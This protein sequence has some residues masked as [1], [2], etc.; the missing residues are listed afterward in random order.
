[1]RIYIIGFMGSGKTIFG[2]RLAAYSNFDFLDLDAY[3]E[4]KHQ[5]NMLD[6]FASHSEAAFREME[7]KLLRE[8]IQR[9]QLVI[10]LGGGTPCFHNNMDWLLETGLCVYLQLS[11]KALH[12]RLL[13]SKKKRP[14]LLGKTP[15]ELLT[16]VSSTLAEREK[17]YLRAHIIIPGISLKA[18]PIEQSFQ[19]IIDKETE[20]FK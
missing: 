5:I 16:Y 18:D 14:L 15:D 10:S 8:T 9:D 1:M 20:E 11:P 3:F 7:S 12:N 17:Y 19:K 6:F 2:R 13:H 4:E